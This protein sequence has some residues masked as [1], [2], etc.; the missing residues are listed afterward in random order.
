MRVLYSVLK[1]VVAV[2]SVAMAVDVAAAGVDVFE[3]Q[4]KAL[5]FLDSRTRAVLSM[6]PKQLELVHTEKSMADARYA[7]YY[8]FN[9]DDGNAFVI[10]AGDDRAV[11]V[12]A[13]GTR[14]LDMDHIPCNMQWMLNH[15]KK[16]M[17][18]LR[19]N[20]DMFL[21]NAAVHSE[22]VV[23]PLVSCTWNQR[24]PFYNHCPTSGTQ[25]C[26]TGCIATAMA[27]VMYYWKYPA[28]APAMESYT[29]EVNGVTVGALPG[30]TFDWDNMLDVYTT[31]AT[32]QQK[33]AV[34]MLMRY[35][36]QACHMGYGASA[37]GAYSEDELAGMKLFGYNADAELLDRDD[38]SAQ[39]WAAM[40]EA[41]L[42]AGCPILYGGVDA[43]K[44]A[45]HAFVVDGCG[46]GM[47][48]VNWGYSGS[49]DGYFVLDAFTTMNITFSSEQQMLYQVYPAGYMY[50]RHAPVMELATNVGTTS[51]TASWTDLTPS[52]WV[53]DYTLYVQPYDSSAHEVVLNETFAA[54]N[55][56]IDATTAL[57]ANKVGDY[58]D[59]PGWTGS[60]VY[61]GAG[62]CFIVG[63]QKYVGSL[64]TPPLSPGADGK[65]TVRFRSRYYGSENSVALVG[66]GDTQLT[67]PLTRMATEY[68]VVFD[69]VEDGAKVTF[70]CTGRASRFYLDDVV[71]TKGDDRSPVDAG[72]M[73]FSDLTTRF[74]TVEQLETGATYRYQV[75][76]RYADG[77]T[78]QSNLQLVTLLEHQDHNYTAG[79]VNHD[80]VLDVLDVT[81]LIGYI[82]D[83]PADVCTDCADVNGDEEIDVAD[84]T[85]LIAIILNSQQ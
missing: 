36:G 41:Q 44:N 58:C 61:L 4:N 63:G 82:L 73:V 42:A 28:E 26:L 5:Q 84:V 77:M 32:A 74:Y 65:I 50:G 22:V 59:N 7:D 29:S 40:I 76:S 19:M 43:D 8:I 33:D 49:G 69:N 6:S 54:I 27:Q 1:L 35:C 72:A 9:A 67:I 12:L 37:S 34:A 71:V 57:S 30:C 83:T 75:V 78:K 13:Y 23:S 14:A 20:P 66:C 80:D 47:Y 2:T 81:L 25:H 62:G 46:G 38:Y 56:N 21:D 17:D 60:F 48:H 31:S 79:D 45:G 53:I 3:A 52:D 68:T 11:D 85:S 18:F 51:F 10:V 16:Q 70:G 15:Y 39:D 55:V 64:S 24:S